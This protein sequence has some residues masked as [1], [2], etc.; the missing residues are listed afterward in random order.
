MCGRAS[1]TEGTANTESLAARMHLWFA[2]DM[3]QGLEWNQ[4]RAKTVK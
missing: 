2:Q 4:R 1:E 3:A